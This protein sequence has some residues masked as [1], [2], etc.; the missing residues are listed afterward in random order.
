MPGWKAPAVKALQKR[1]E[2]AA[3]VTRERTLDS[4]TA[5]GS[6]VTMFRR[7]GCAAAL[8]TLVVPHY[9]LFPKQSLFFD[10]K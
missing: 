7:D 2:G 5:E 3:A 8:V 9:W 10:R 4:I 1:H 6:S